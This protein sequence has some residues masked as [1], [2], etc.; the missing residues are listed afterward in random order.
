[1]AAYC[2]ILLHYELSLRW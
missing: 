2:L 1:M